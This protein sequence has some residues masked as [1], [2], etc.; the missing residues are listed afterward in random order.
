MRQ[1]KLVLTGLCAI[2]ALIAAAPGAQAGPSEDYT[3]VRQD[4]LA[5]QGRQVTAC[6]FSLTKLQSARSIASQNPE[7]SYNGFPEAVD[8]EIG[9]VNRGLCGLPAGTPTPGSKLSL[10]VAPKSVRRRHRATFTFTVTGRQG[11]TKIAVRG[12]RVTFQG[13]RKTTD[14][15]GRVKITKLFRSAGTRTAGAS[16][17]GVRSA[18]T[19][20]RVRR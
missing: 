9:R 10:G 14:R 11:S 13:F 6:R 19:T 17:R 3:A 16:Y 18:T 20:V 7:D 12:A 1:G 8:R 15:R 5:N 2:A 4:F